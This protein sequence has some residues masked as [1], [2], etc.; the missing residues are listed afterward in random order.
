MRANTSVLLLYQ[1]SDIKQYSEKYFQKSSENN[2]DGVFF[3][4]SCRLWGN[5]RKVF[6]M[7]F[8]GRIF[9]E[10]FQVSF[11]LKQL[12][13][14]LKEFWK[15]LQFCASKFWHI[16][17][18]LHSNF[19]GA[20]DIRHLPIDFRNTNMELFLLFNYLHVLAQLYHKIIIW[21]TKQ[22]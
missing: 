10:I 21:L 14:F 2:C 5:G 20:E 16:R 17:F 3:Q 4:W 12:R 7:A 22:I 18:G 9:C 13:I 11:F 19:R 8:F 6:I 1:C 15:R